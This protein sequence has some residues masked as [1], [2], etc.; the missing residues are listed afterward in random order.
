MYRLIKTDYSSRCYPTKVQDLNYLRMFGAVSSALQLLN[1][2]LDMINCPASG[3]LSP[4][5]SFTQKRA[6]SVGTQTDDDVDNVIPDSKP[7][8]FI[9]IKSI[10]SGETVGP[11]CD[12]DSVDSELV[13]FDSPTGDRLL[14]ETI[15][16]LTLTPTPGMDQLFE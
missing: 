14:E 6:I 13:N 16:P 15:Q 9:P 12:F 4:R 5:P 1:R 7:I 10:G 2:R 8:G 11:T 3:I